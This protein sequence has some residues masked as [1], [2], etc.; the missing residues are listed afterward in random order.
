MHVRSCACACMR[1]WCTCACMHV[2]VHVCVSVHMRAR[3]RCAWVHTR[4]REFVRAGRHECML[5]SPLT[6][7]KSPHV[8]HLGVPC[9]HVNIHVH[10]HAFQLMYLHTSIHMLH[11]CLHRCLNACFYQSLIEH[12]EPDKLVW[13]I[14]RSNS[15]EP[16]FRVAKEIVVQRV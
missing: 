4:M 15:L 13:V 9:P 1:S 2:C 12:G 11:T 10:T 6:R 7:P 16:S 5:A 8:A 14:T 3:D